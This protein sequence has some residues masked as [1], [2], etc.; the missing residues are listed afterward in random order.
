MPVH[1]ADIAAVFEEIADLL[2]IRNENP[3]RVRAYRNAA[4]QLQGMGVAAADMVARG[5][6]LTELPGIGTDLAA[7]IE[8]I[9][10]TGRCRV[11][12]SLHRQVPHSVT[13]LLNIRG[14]G[15]KRVRALYQ[16]L[17]VQ[18]LEQLAR[19]ARDGRI[20]ELPGFGA[21]T[22]QAI[23]EAV[24][25]QVSEQPRFKLA[26]AA[27]YA[28]PLQTWLEKI[29]GVKQVVVAGSYRRCRETVG[30]LD[31]LVTA[32]TAGVLDQIA[33]YDE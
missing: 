17:D 28:E 1:N 27:Q 31:I 22:E 3:F 32:D 25:R 14:L 9:V 7:R 19:A 33:A 4:R 16:E 8:E 2:E 20:R 26:V 23:L 5:D 13:E 29:S 21:R 30:D 15:P 10:E 24:S 18:T 12:E 6:D 11:L